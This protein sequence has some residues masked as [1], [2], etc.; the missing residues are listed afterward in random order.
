MDKFERSTPVGVYRD[1]YTSTENDMHREELMLDIRY[2]VQR[3]LQRYFGEKE[4]ENEDIRD[5]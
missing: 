1:C 4:V 5:N 2:K 3:D